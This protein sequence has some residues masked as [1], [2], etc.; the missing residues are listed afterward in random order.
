[1]YGTFSGM[2][3]S[4][5]AG[6]ALLVIAFAFFASPLLAVAIALIAILGFIVGMAALRARSREAE[7]S[8]VSEPGTGPAG[9]RARGTGG[10]RASGEPA[11]GEGT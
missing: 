11:S 9:P 10:R 1:M 3:F 6:V 7:Q 8:D 4:I 5:V 2:S